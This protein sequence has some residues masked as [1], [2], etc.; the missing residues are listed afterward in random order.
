LV[1]QNR[2]R[3]VQIV[4]RRRGFAALQIS[5]SASSLFRD[6]DFSPVISTRSPPPTETNTIQSVAVSTLIPS[7]SNPKL[8]TC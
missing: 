5:V 1:T 3:E 7:F 6:L 2:G 8:F 4:G